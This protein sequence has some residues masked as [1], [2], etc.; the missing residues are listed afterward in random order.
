VG[1]ANSR[2]RDGYQ[3]SLRKAK[4]MNTLY[5]V[6][7]P[8]LCGQDEIINK[9]LKTSENIT[10]VVSEGAITHALT[11]EG[12][13][14]VELKYSFISATVRSHLFVGYDVIANCDNLSVEALVLWK[15]LA[16]EHE[17]KCII[18]LLC[19]V[20]AEAMEKI[21]N[22][23]IDEH[24]KQKM[25]IKL[26]DQFKM[27]DDL[28]EVLDNKINSITR[29]LADDVYHATFEAPVEVDR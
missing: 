29:E 11:L 28:A 10:Q 6:V 27:F 24:Q 12:I 14:D 20:E 25:Y 15:R 17:A 7:G 3:I 8:E 23:T 21:E 19:G 2:N 26:K 5:V 18:V 1:I 4:I 13:K 16:A 9:F 22:L